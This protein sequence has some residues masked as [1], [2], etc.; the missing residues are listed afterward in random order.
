MHERY[1]VYS[2]LYFIMIVR[3]PTC[4]HVLIPNDDTHPIHCSDVVSPSSIRVA[5]K[6]WHTYRKL[7][8]Q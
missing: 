7:A 5:R 4:E 1:S 2:D 6:A 3:G 8:R